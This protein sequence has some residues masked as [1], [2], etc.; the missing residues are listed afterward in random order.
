M[1]RDRYLF[2][3]MKIVVAITGS[4]T[5]H[6]NN[7][8][9]SLLDGM[10]QPSEILVTLKRG[11][12]S[13]SEL[14]WPDKVHILFL[15]DDY[16][17]LTAIVGA[18]ERYPAHS[19]TY[20]LFLNSNC[21]YPPHLIKEYEQ[22]VPDLEKALREK[23]PNNNGSVYGLSGVVMA[24]DKQ[25]NLDLEFRDLIG[26][27]IDPYE[28]RNTLGYVREN[29]TVDYLESCGSVL[30]H[31]SQLK[32]DF[33]V[34]LAKAKAKDTGSEL[35]P[36][37]E[38]LSMDVILSNYFAKHRFLR[39]QICNF[40]INRFMLIRAGYFQNYRELDEQDKRDLYERTVKHLR[41]KGCFYTYE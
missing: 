28:V 29:A 17:S 13:G 3:L 40:A 11:S 31:R 10:I 39:T 7:A 41:S 24:P 12:G 15:D 4:D 34:Y 21:T 25:R 22:C 38:T 30:I 16:G 5:I 19:D 32:D 37:Q 35:A 27:P 9:K 36:N 8:V 6:I 1:L 26:K 23:L 18:M 14:G 20:I 2:L 33:L